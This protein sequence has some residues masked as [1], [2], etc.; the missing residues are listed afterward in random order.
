MKTVSSRTAIIKPVVLWL[1][2]LRGHTDAWIDMKPIL[3]VAALD[4]TCFWKL[5]HTTMAIDKNF[6]LCLHL[7]LF[8]LSFFL[9]RKECHCLRLKWFVEVFSH[10]RLIVQII[11][12][13]VACAIANKPQSYVPDCICKSTNLS[14]M[15]GCWV[16]SRLAICAFASV[17]TSTQAV[18]QKN[19]GMLCANCCHSHPVPLTSVQ[20]NG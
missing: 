1:K 7:P 18:E 4:P 15:T 8:V 5:W 11:S 17:G 13:A 14:V 10:L 2:C 9:Q 16:A 3:A 12:S 6:F 20:Y 19:F